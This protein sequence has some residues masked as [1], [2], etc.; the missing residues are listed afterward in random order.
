MNIKRCKEMIYTIKNEKLVVS[1][2]SYGAEAVSVI[3]NGKEWIW[4]NSTGDWAGH[5][6][7]LFPVC[8][9]FGVTVNGKSYP[10]GAHGFVR[11]TECTLSSIGDDYIDFLI[12]ANDATKAVYPFDFTLHIIYRISGANL[13]VEYVV[14]NPSDMPLYFACGSHESYA[15]D[16]N[17]DGY[18]LVFEKEEEFV[19]YYHDDGGYLTGE[20]KNFGSGK[21][22]ALPRDFLQNSATLIFKN[23]KSR[24]VFLCQKGGRALAKAHFDGFANLLLWRAGDSPFICIEP[25]TNLPDFAGEAD[26]EFATKEGVIEVAPKSVKRMMHSVEYL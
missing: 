1:V 23:I 13:T 2:D 18:E 22:F 12:E 9:H 8:G 15:L 16:R 10:I 19:H 3:A 21:A 5:S 7:I 25:W 26:K 6:P 20:T 17:V 24:E 14:E 11:K 4:Q